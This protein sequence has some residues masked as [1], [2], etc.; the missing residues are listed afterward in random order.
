MIPET[1][2]V[3]LLV[4][5]SPWEAPKIEDSACSRERIEAPLLPLLPRPTCDRLELPFSCDAILSGYEDLHL[6]CSDQFTTWG[7]MT[8]TRF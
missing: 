2:K 6:P 3:S 7:K 8:L 1:P 5:S 4:S